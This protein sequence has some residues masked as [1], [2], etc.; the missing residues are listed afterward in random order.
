M[1]VEYIHCLNKNPFIMILV[2]HKRLHNIT[3]NT[4]LNILLRFVS[5]NQFMLHFV[6]VVN[7]LTNYHQ[8]KRNFSYM[9]ILLQKKNKNYFTINKTYNIPTLILVC[10]YGSIN[11][12]GAL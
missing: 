9:N 10:L 4:F 8:S 1:K 2:I 3:K 7:K 6:C 5:T 11:K 12:K